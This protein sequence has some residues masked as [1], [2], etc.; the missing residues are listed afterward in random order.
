M[1]ELKMS[2]PLDSDNFLR[3]QCSH[4]ERQFKWL[5]NSAEQTTPSPSHY[6][7][8]YGHQAAPKDEWWTHEQLA[9]VKELATQKIV[10]PMLNTFQNDLERLNH[11]GSL[12]K[13]NV[14]VSNSR[15]PAPL[16]EKD[17]MRRVDFSC[18]PNEPLKVLD[19][20]KEPVGCLICGGLT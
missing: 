17:D 9:Y 14:S 13:V 12:I 5:P 1:T 3:R 15:E 10:G 2:L 18:H 7:C 6:K 8:P 20:W 19:E 16:T 4:C 11:P